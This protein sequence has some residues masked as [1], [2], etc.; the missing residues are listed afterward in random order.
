MRFRF[1]VLF[2]FCNLFAGCTETEPVRSVPFHAIEP[3]GVEI[4]D[5]FE[6]R[7]AGRLYQRTLNVAGHAR[8]VDPVLLLAIVQVSVGGD[9]SKWSGRE[10]P[11][12]AYGP[13]QV[14]PEQLRG[15]WSENFPVPSSCLQRRSDTDG[16]PGWGD[17]Y[18]YNQPYSDRHEDRDQQCDPIYSGPGLFALQHNSHECRRYIDSNVGSAVYANAVANMLAA[19][20]AGTHGVRSEPRTWYDTVLWFARYNSTYA[21]RPDWSGSYGEVA[22]VLPRNHWFAR[23]VEERH[24]ALCVAARAADA[25]RRL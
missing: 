24:R 13:F 18:C 11:H 20:R 12:G 22:G 2:I 4:P 15:Y 3:C 10:S 25:S 23:R 19:I 17:G 9:S 7:H 5:A 21:Y 16:F 14:T 1:H 6:F 8:G